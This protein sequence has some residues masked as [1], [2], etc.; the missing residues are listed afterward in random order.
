MLSTFNG[1]TVKVPW[2]KAIE[3]NSE[4]RE[5]KRVGSQ[6]REKIL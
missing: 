2:L 3:T 4:G 5:K 1:E 6:K